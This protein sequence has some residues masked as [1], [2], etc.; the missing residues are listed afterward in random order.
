MSPDSDTTPNTTPNTAPKTSPEDELLMD[1]QE[2]V[3]SRTEVERG[4]IEHHSLEE[5][6]APRSAEPSPLPRRRETPVNTDEAMAENF[7]SA[8][9][10]RP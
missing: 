7:R 6:E 9:N 8:F 1:G 2:E 4:M 10:P 3:F 5:D